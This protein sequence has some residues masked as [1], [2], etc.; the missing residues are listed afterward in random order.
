MMSRKM[1]R[2]VNRNGYGWRLAA[3]VLALTAAAL[4][5]CSS[6][7]TLVP[8]I[9]TATQFSGT[10]ANVAATMTSFRSAIGGVNNGGVAA[11]Q[12]SGRRE[13][14]WD[15]I[16]MAQ[17]D[18]NS[19]GALINAN[20]LVIAAGRFGTRGIVLVEGDPGSAGVPGNPNTFVFTAVSDNGFAS[21][22]PS[23]AGRFLAFSPTKTFAPLNSN[24]TEVRFVNPTPTGTSAVSAGTSAFGAVF[25]DVNQPGTSIEAF[26]GFRSL[27]RFAVPTSGAGGTSF[28]GIQY[29]SNVITS[30]KLTTGT[31]VLATWTGNPR[32]L[33]SGPSDTAATD[34]VA[35]DDFIYAEPGPAVILAGSTF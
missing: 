18:F 27:G 23:T 33:S 26:N 28:L 29:S 30:V 16:T 11:P 25:L 19:T 15:G 32:V 31:A 10:D 14:N 20:T 22:N 1:L 6:S 3:A 4:H 34:Q 13:I 2:N 12:G 8:A 5:G 7:D 35:M 9:P 21:A 17:S 24:V